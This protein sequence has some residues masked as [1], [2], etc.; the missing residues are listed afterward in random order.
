MAQWQNDLESKTAPWLM[1]E[2]ALSHSARAELDDKISRCVDFFEGRQWASATE[3]TKN[4][5]RPVVNIVKMICRSKKASLLSSPLKLYYKSYTQGIN[6]SRLNAFARCLLLEL[7]E[8]ALDRLALDDAIK[9]GSCFY[10]Y[11]WDSTTLSL[12]GKRQGSVRCEII[13]PLCI[14]FENPAQLDEQK[15]KWII[16]STKLEP[17]EASLI[18]DSP[19]SLSLLDEDTDENGLV[20]VLT[21][22]FRQNGEVYF[23][24]VSKTHVLCAPK[25]L[26]PLS[27]KDG[28]SACTLYPVVCGYYEK[29]EGSIYGI[30]EV[31]GL[32]PNQ[33]AINFNIAM[34]L[35]NAQEC[36]WGKYIALPGALKGQKISNVPG[37]VL[38][39]HAG[40][41]DGIKKMSDSALS[42]VP[43]SISD[44]LISITRS[45]TGATE[46]FSGEALSSNMSGT[47]IAQLQAQAQLPIEDLR[48]ELIEIKRKQGLVLAQF[49]K[50]YFYAK[51]FIVTEQDQSGTRQVL[52]LFYS[53]DY[54]SSLLDVVVEV[55]NSSRA[56]VSS[57]ISFLNSCLGTGSISLETYIKAYPDCAISNKAELLAHLQEQ[58]GLELEALIKE[59]YELKQ[60]LTQ[61]GKSPINSFEP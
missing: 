29:K 13:D 21:R 27:S 12:T 41:G 55:T 19:I 54:A 44:D 23:E 6:V 42:T 17:S 53:S 11:Y 16:I 1:Y 43:M 30:S 15:Q 39:D 35:L 40:T 59:N 9:K 37:Q 34:S 10:H 58:R 49:I 45:V 3:S 28:V 36:A 32:I 18:A 5:P 61:N 56:T 52:D 48:N 51:E 33:K 38:I 57:D 24:K 22:Y 26:S 46:I 2:K 25:R 47:A 4:L 31:E 7:G 50:Q 14:F 20:T 8:S 60:K